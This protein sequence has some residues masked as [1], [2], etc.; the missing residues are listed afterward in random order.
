MAQAVTFCAFGAEEFCGFGAEE[1]RA[2]GAE[3]KIG[4]LGSCFT[5]K[6]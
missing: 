1:F 5:L 2:F 6:A 4:E 3:E